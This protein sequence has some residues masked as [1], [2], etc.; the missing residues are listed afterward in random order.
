MI[1]T[2]MEYVLCYSTAF[3]LGFVSCALLVMIINRGEVK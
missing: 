2:I 1:N 3:G